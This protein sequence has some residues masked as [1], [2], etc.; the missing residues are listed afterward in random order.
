MCK[1]KSTF[2][3]YLEEITSGCPMK[4]DIVTEATRENTGKTTFPRLLIFK[5]QRLSKKINRTIAYRM[6]TVEGLPFS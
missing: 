4:K 5:T 3:L 6:L 1:E 2:G